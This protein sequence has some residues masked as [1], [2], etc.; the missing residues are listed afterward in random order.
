[1]QSM[2]DVPW[3]VLDGLVQRTQQP[4][5]LFPVPVNLG[6]RAEMADGAAQRVL[7]EVGLVDMSCPVRV[8]ARAFRAR[9]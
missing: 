1:M 4:K 2:I 3:G 7:A 8:V 6:F 9:V 5:P